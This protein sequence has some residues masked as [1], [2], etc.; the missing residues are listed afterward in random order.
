MKDKKECVASGTKKAYD[1]LKEKEG[2]AN[3]TLCEAKHLS[4]F[5]SLTLLMM[6]WFN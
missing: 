4:F 6:L 5:L 1:M 3:P 2:Q